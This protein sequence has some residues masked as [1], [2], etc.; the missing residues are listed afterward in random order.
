MTVI[1][2]PDYGWVAYVQHRPCPDLPAARRYYQRAGAVLALLTALEASDFH[3]ENVIASGEHPVPVDLE[4]LLHPRPRWLD[5]N[6]RRSRS[7]TRR[8]GRCRRPC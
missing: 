8:P 2:R 6:G 1:A 5:T 7:Q 4:G 3:Y